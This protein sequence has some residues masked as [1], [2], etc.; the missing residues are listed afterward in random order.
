MT[1]RGT[2]TLSYFVSLFLSLSLVVLLLLDYFSTTLPLT[3]DISPDTG[4]F[5]V[6]EWKLKVAQAWPGWESLTKRAEGS[7]L[8][9]YQW[10]GG[11][12]EERKESRAKRREE[13]E[14]ESVKRTPATYMTIVSAVWPTVASTVTRTTRTR[15]TRGESAFSGTCTG[16]PVTLDNSGNNRTIYCKSW[17]HCCH[18]WYKQMRTGGVIDEKQRTLSCDTRQA[19]SRWQMKSGKNEMPSHTYTHLYT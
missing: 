2:V 3:L 18:W 19:C 13:R 9:S 10:G 4:L 11:G 14:R 5:S 7:F 8:P 1:G 17:R 6:T 16:H 12:G 15:M